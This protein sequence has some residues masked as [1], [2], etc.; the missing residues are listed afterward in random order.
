MSRTGD[1]RVWIGGLLLL[2]LLVSVSLLVSLSRDGVGDQ[3]VRVDRQE[4]KPPSAGFQ[5]DARDQR[6][7][8]RSGRKRLGRSEFLAMLQS[9]SESPDFRQASRELSS[10]DLEDLKSILADSTLPDDVRQAAA[11]LLVQ[12]DD[13]DGIQA[14]LAA[15]IDEADQTPEFRDNLLQILGGLHSEAAAEALIN[16]WAAYGNRQDHLPLDLR[17][18]IMKLLGS[19]PQEF[20]VGVR[21]AERYLSSDDP[22]VQR[23]LI[24]LEFPEMLAALAVEADRQGDAQQVGAYID[25]LKHLGSIDTVNGFQMLARKSVLPLDE[26]SRMAYDWARLNDVGRIEERLRNT[27][28]SPQASD[29]ERVVSAYALAAWGEKA[30]PILEKAIQYE[31]NETLRAELSKALSLSRSENRKEPIR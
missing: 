26:V 17:R 23:A 24:R 7:D 14:V 28:S 25:L 21:M 9:G 3:G 15:L 27:L 22:E 6:P 13:K 16:F 31:E 20:Q 19:F 12:S 8:A 18:L 2:L 10:A 30:A 29:E 11:K 4:T 1:R 5:S